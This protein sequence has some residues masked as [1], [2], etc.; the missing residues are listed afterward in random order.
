VNSGAPA[1]RT[2]TTIEADEGVASSDFLGEKQRERGG[3]GR[4]TA[5]YLQLTLII[6]HD[7]FNIVYLKLRL[8]F[9]LLSDCKW[10]R[11]TWSR[12]TMAEDRLCGLFMLHVHRNDTVR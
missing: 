6:D 9:S 4:R 5:S 3:W 8:L 2:V 1:H 10:C 12:A 11:N 7:S